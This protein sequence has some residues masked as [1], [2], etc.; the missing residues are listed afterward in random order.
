MAQE[1]VARLRQ[2]ADELDCYTQDD[3][4]LLGDIGEVTEESWRKRGKGPPAIRCGNRFLYPRPGV[5]VWLQSLIKERR[6]APVKD[7]L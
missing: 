7:A 4:Q 3:L 1:D 2:L 6:P 5:R